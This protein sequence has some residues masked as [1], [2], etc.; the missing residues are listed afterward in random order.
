MNATSSF[1]GLEA[2]RIQAIT[3]DLD[4]TLWPVWPTIRNAEAALLDWMEEHV[5]ATAAYWRG[6]GGA[7][8]IRAHVQAAHPAHGHD[9]SFLRRQ[10][11]ARALELAGDD[12]ALADAGFE[13]FFAARQRVQLFD[14]VEAALDRLASRYPLLALSNGNADVMGMPIGRYF[15]GSLPARE[16]GV[17]KPDP[18]I[19][20]MAADRLGLASGDVLHVGDDP[21]LDVAGAQTAG[22]QAVWLNR[23]GAAWQDP[24]RTPP[25]IADL[26]VLARWLVR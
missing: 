11:I 24:A 20:A 7:Q 16:A 9:F 8:A 22:M 13:A 3:L 18:R 1:A 14:E 15:K 6:E 2:H 10:M 23:D 5:P 12:P 17:A 25:Q 4:D 19:F 26:H 21:A